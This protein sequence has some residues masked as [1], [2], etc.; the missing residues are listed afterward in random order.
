M[1]QILP[2][3]CSGTRA[4]I[5]HKIKVIMKLTVVLML[6]FCLG[7]KAEGYA[8][9]V[10]LSV[11]NAS[12]EKVFT[13]IKKQTGYFFLYDSELLLKASNISIDIRNA[14][15]EEA[16]KKCVSGQPLS[17]R[18]ID[19]TITISA[20]PVQLPAKAVADI[21][22]RGTVKLKNKNGSVETAPGVAVTVKGT[23][24]ATGTDFDGSYAISVSEDATLVFSYIGFERQE[25]AVKGQT[26]INV[27]LIEAVNELNEVVITGYGIKERKENQVGS[28]VTVSSAEL[29]NRPVDRIDKLLDGI[30]PGMQVEF[31]SDDA[32]SSRP[33]FQT[34]IR[35]EASFR[36]SN[37]PLWIVD[38]VPLYTGGETNLISGVQTSISPL[39]YLNPKDIES[40]TILKD[41]SATTIYGANGANG[42]VL[43][44]TKSG[45]GGNKLSYNFR[46]GIN[47]V[48]DTRFQMLNGDEY[49]ELLKESYVNA[50]MIP[51]A[52][53]NE[54]NVNTNWADLYFRNGSTTE[55]N[56][57][58]SGGANK[59][60]YYIGGSYYNEKQT[61]I[62]NNTE[63]FST[64]LNLDQEVGSRLKLMFKVGGSLNKNNLFSPGDS[65]FTNRPNINPFNA[66][67]SYA[68]RDALTNQRLM[69]NLAEAEQNDN[70]QKAFAVTG[71][72]GGELKLTDGLFFTSTNG[73]DYSDVQ[74]DIYK[75]SRN[76]SGQSDGGIS[77]RSSANVLRWISI[78]RF[79]FNRQFGKHDVE[80]V[81]GSE[82][83]EE[84]RS[85]RYAEGWGFAND[86]I[87]EVT[88]AVTRKGGS[89]AEENSS[90]SMFS[91]LGYTWDRKYSL[92]AN[93]RRD[94]NSRFGKNVRWADFSSVGASWTISNEPFW[95]SKAIDLAK[96]KLSYGTNGNSRFSDD[97]KGLYAFSTDYNYNG[98]PGTIM[99][100]G[101]NPVY[102]W[103]TTYML[104][105]GINM[106]FF[107]RISFE[108]E[109]YRNYTKNLI[110]D[111]DV[112]RTTG[113]T[114]I[115]QNVGELENKGV[116]LTL[117][118]TNIQSKDIRWT[119][120]F[121]IAH[122]KNTIKELYNGN[123]KVFDITF[124]RVGEDANTLYLIRWA[125]VDPRDGAPL[126]YDANDNIT[127]VFSTN[128]RVAVGSST[129]D[130]FGG[131]TNSFTYKDFTLSAL[132]KYTVG[133][134]AF[135]GL[136][137][138]TE[139]DGRSIGDYNQSRNQLDR[140]REPGD[141]VLAP[142]PIYNQNANSGRNSTRFLH[143]KTNIQ[144]S[145]VSLDYRLP[146]GFLSRF[147]IANGSIYA[148]AD[149]LGFWTPYEQTN[150][151]NTYR[152]SFSPFP[153][154]RVISFGITVGF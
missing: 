29:V 52:Y 46:S 76:L 80:A 95:K 61:I 138:S 86:K 115:N 35:G 51:P 7:V 83:S 48:T 30:V 2:G 149:N 130:F 65:Y 98:Q 92:I 90:L 27:V 73:I 131:M 23:N 121:N 53:L 105:T 20:K 39:S 8:Q 112:T 132:V 44:T 57:S 9:K 37:E 114:K 107:N 116:E 71:N 75:S 12:L 93:Y 144:L 119:T 16:L 1:K 140:W 106:S 148:Q 78:N 77:L 31:Q 150:G 19:R 74:E 91:R 60:R 134:Y 69:N 146:A 96:L 136:R 127:R 128:N 55:H 101:E 14:E 5:P 117:N 49:V 142:K 42:V 147:G 85:S 38:G 120:R 145:N 123:D 50:G 56:L 26:S 15:I 40:I 135:S 97:S 34:R 111:V 118:T 17:Y 24:R 139:S 141:L 13:E 43:I 104:N 133:G 129:P 28:A 122:N 47:A 32:T 99:S 108:F 10:N 151:R 36:A 154:E 124:R 82:A 45:G 4:L 72:I 58:F 67:G 87:K 103:E 81:L 62:A 68:L 88:Y 153:V 102:S 6:A 3:K 64:R 125:G 79:N 94:G 84:R 11:R 18:I 126:W 22:V 63:R 137:R 21:I 152:N 54:R 41:A 110:D 70:N 25:I 89:N 59:T 66:D 100:S 143:E 113:S 33:R 109:F